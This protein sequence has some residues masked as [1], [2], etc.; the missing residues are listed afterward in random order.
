MVAE[1]KVRYIGIFA[2]GAT[3]REI[4]LKIAQC[5]LEGSGTNNLSLE[6]VMLRRQSPRG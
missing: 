1:D 3:D 5:V 4:L 2:D 6:P